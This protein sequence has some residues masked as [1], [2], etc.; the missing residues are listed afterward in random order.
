MAD[1]QVTIQEIREWVREFREKRGWDRR[2]NTK[3][4]AISLVLEAGEFLE[5]YQWLE[6]EEVEGDKERKQEAEFELADVLYWLMA[7]ADAYNMD[8][9]KTLKEKLAKGDK[10]YLA[11]QFPKDLPTKEGLKRY[12]ALK[13]NHD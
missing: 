8:L 1:K 2:D 13:K 9:S 7:I 12:Y 3:N 5:H 11:E 6:G 10:R 4:M